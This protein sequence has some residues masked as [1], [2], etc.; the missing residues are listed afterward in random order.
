MPRLGLDRRRR[1]ALLLVALVAFWFAQAVAVAHAS[2][3]AGGDAPGLP[4]DRAQFC[5]DCVSMLPLLAVA[6]GVGAAVAFARPVVR[7]VRAP[8]AVRHVA[9]AI[10]HPF[11]SR[12]PPR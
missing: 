6:G 10:H 12:A 2:R 11:R 1:N 8:V 9:T 4:A 5:T 3:H 7:S